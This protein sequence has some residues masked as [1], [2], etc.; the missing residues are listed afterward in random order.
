[1]QNLKGKKIILTSVLKELRHQKSYMSNITI[2]WYKCPPSLSGHNE[3]ITEVRSQLTFFLSTHILLH[4]W[5]ATSM[6]LCIIHSFNTVASWFLARHYFISIQFRQFT[7]MH[8]L[9][10]NVS[11]TL[12]CRQ[13]PLRILFKCRSWFSGSEE[14]GTMILHFYNLPCD[15]NAT[16]P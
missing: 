2:I 11:Q 12:I 4:S 8:I 7:F 10:T 16:G 3:Y 1:M 14:W 5:W 6:S 13:Y 9:S 15:A